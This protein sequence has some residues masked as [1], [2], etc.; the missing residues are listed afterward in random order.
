M[1]KLNI[2][3]MAR[4]IAGITTVGA[5]LTLTDVG[6]LV[7]IVI[8]VLGFLA[9]TLFTYRRDRREQRESEARMARIRKRSKLL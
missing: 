7:G 6:A 3:D 8:A 9:N 4:L 1:N 5:S 2:P